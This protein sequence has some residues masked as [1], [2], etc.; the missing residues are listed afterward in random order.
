M[1]AAAAAVG[2]HCYG[3]HEF[4]AETKARVADE[5]ARM[6]ER[7]GDRFDVSPSDAP[8]LS[9]SSARPT[10]PST[11]SSPR[12]AR[13]V[14]HSGMPAPSGGWTRT[15]ASLSEPPKKTTGCWMR[16]MFETTGRDSVCQIRREGARWL[17]TAWDGGYRTADAVYNVTVPEGFER[18]DLDAYR[19]ERLS[20]A[21]FAVGPTLLTV[22]TWN[23]PACPE[24]VGVGAG[25]SGSLEPRRVADV[26]SGDSR[27]L[28][29]DCVESGGRPDWRPGTAISS[30]VSTGRWTRARWRRCSPPPSRRGCD[31]ARRGKRPRNHIGRGHRRLCPERRARLF[32]GSA[33]ELGAATRVCVRDAIRASLAARYGGDALPTVD[34][35]E[36]GVVADGFREFRAARTVT[37]DG[38]GVANGETE[39][40]RQTDMSD[41]PAGPTA[42]PISPPRP[43]T[44]GSCRSGGA[45]ARERPR[46]RW[47]W[48]FAPPATATA[49]TCCSS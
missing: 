19:A 47:A 21:G 30:S 29:R 40:N 27:R 49:S 20:G 10:S 46:R 31:A 6:R 8:F 39:S 17:S 26:G 23:T 12:P 48:A 38:P 1:S 11:I 18:T 35:A 4:V 44:S 2:A 22:F 42:E 13:L 5:R 9:L 14:S 37:H 34:G 16:W 15:S 36:Y 33:T 28:R 45:T 43:T 41:N 3:Q 24:R 25:D 32:A 7:L